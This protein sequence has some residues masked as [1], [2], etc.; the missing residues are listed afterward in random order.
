MISWS[1]GSVSNRGQI[2]A[3]YLTGVTST[4]P[5]IYGMLQHALICLVGA[6]LPQDESQK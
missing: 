6:L 4:G 2:E 3:Y 5:C 1:D